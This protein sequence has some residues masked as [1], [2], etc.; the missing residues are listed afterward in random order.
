MFFLHSQQLAAAKQAEEKKQLK[1]LVTDA[2]ID[3]VHRAPDEEEEQTE[4][5]EKEKEKAAAAAAAAKVD[6]AVNAQI[7]AIHNAPL[8]EEQ[9][10]KK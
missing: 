10:K 5:E 2:H 4:G 9:T 7:E 8:E 1:S 3:Q 6:P